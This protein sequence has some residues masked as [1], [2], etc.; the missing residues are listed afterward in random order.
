MKTTG[1]LYRNSVSH[2]PV[3]SQSLAILSLNLCGCFGL[4]GVFLS[5]NFRQDETKY[6]Y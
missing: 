3:F 1:L 5:V 6:E 2:I 4:F